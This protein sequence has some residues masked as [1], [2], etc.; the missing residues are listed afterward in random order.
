MSGHQLATIVTY[1]V[2]GDGTL[3]LS[4]E[5]CYPSLRTLPRDTFGTLHACHC[6]QQRQVFFCDVQA[7]SEYP[8]EFS[9]DGILTIFSFDQNKRLRITRRCFPCVEQAAYMETATIEN[10][11]DAP[12][13][14]CVSGSDWVEYARGAVGVYTI[15]AACA[16][17]EAQL[18]PGQSITS[19]LTFSARLHLLPTPAPTAAQLWPSGRISAIG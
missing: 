1:G 16:E 18:Q 13:R 14:V 2:A 6:N 4:R 15:E 10:C 8:V 7:V 19:D 3:S 9:F 12:L 17:Q 11:A 5:L